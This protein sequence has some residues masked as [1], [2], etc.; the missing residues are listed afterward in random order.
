MNEPA[1]P[2]EAISPVVPPGENFGVASAPEPD[3]SRAAGDPA[4]VDQSELIKLCAANNELFTRVFFSKTVPQKS[5]EFHADVDRSLESNKRLINIQMFRGS[6]KTTKLRIFM[7]RRIAYGT[8][9]TIL[10]VARSEAKAIHSVQ[11]L[12]KQIEHNKKFASTFKL[13]RGDK[14][15]EAELKIEHKLFGHTVSVLALGITGS[16]R[17]INIEDHRPDLIIVDD[18]VDEENA[19]TPEQRKKISDWVY[20]SLINSLVPAT[21]VPDAKLVMIQTPLNREDVSTLALTDSAWVSTRYGCWTKETENLDDAEKVSNWPERFPTAD[22]LEMKRQ[23][24]RRNKASVFAREMEC[25]I[26]SPE[27]AAFFSSW[28]QFYDVIPERHLM[29]VAV[30]IDPVPPPTE[31][32]IAEGLRKK[33]WEA[34]YVWGLSYDGY[35]LLDRVRNRGHEPDWTLNEF[36]RLGA[37]WRPQFFV[38]ETVAYQKTLEWILR[39]AMQMNRQYYQIIEFTDPRSK[40]DRISDALIGPASNGKLFVRGEHVEFIQ[41]FN[42]F[43]DI[44]HDDDL[45]ASA[46]AISELVGKEPMIASIMAQ[47]GQENKPRRIKYGYGAP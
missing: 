24:L 47:H 43:P 1:A 2:L 20:G 8:S 12:Q 41:Q 31:K 34:M 21:E 18:I 7:A 40:F 44:V 33:D 5:P 36:F 4:V 11:W 27:T 10:Y 30:G 46:I 17:G 37:K 42:E 32:Q 19:A 13:S 39:K 29:A 26:T 6:A 25:K 14:W 15:T 38:V 28:L 22:L 9:R 3:R 35:F 23:Y 45:D 16:S